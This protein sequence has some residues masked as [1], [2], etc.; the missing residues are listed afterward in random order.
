MENSK[1]DYEFVIKASKELEYILEHDFGAQGRGLQEKISNAASL[2]TFSSSSRRNNGFVVHDVFPT[3]LV[4]DMRY[5]ATIRNKLI[6]EPG[7]DA[8]PNRAALEATFTR[9]VDQLQELVLATKE[10]NGN[11]H[12]RK[13]SFTTKTKKQ[14]QQRQRHYDP[15]VLD[16]FL[17][18][19]GGGDLN[20]CIIS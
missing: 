16:P 7:F 19:C 10:R 12:F 2:R 9:S 17:V 20:S 14:Q 4:Q 11:R 18:A 13:A 3:Q 8:I 15:D 6:H 5:V 1:N